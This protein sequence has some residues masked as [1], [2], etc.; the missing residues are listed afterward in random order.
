MVNGNCTSPLL[1]DTSSAQGTDTLLSIE[2]LK[3]SDA[4]LAIDIEGNAGTTAKII[5]AVFG[6]QALGNK[7]YVGIGLKFLDAGWTHDNLSALALD[8]T[9]A[10]TNDQIVTLLWKNVVG[11]IAINN[12]K[13]PYIGMLENGMTPGAL[14]LMAAD[15][16][17]N[18]ANINLTGLAL[19]GI[20]YTQ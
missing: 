18:I 15:T 2:R 10:K 16:A 13:A 4:N 6:S 8:A 20:V 14:A 19:T 9:G 3:F 12:E 1:V 11:T 7:G 5:G 17:F